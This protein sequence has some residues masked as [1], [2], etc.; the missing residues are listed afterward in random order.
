M[1]PTV[2]AIAIAMNRY[3]EDPPKRALLYCPIPWPRGA[4]QLLLTQRQVDA[5]GSAGRERPTASNRLACLVPLR[6]A[7]HVMRSGPAHPGSDAAHPGDRRPQEPSCAVRD[8]QVAGKSA[9]VLRRA[10]LALAADEIRL[11]H[12]STPLT[13]VTQAE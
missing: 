10:L 5:A 1:P 7:A 9:P 13:D 2:S 8:S 12:A 11:H 4:G 3:I 6:H